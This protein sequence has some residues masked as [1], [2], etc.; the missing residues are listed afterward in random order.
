MFALNLFKK[1][2]LSHETLRVWLHAEGAMLGTIDT[3]LD[4]MNSFISLPFQ[5][6]EHPESIWWL[7][8]VQ[9][10]VHCEAL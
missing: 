3:V 7:S 1:T 6:C 2:M 10:E 4:K 8:Q 9:D 5:V